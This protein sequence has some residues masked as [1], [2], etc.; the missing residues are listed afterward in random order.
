LINK[1]KQPTMTDQQEIINPNFSEVLVPEVSGKNMVQCN[2]SSNVYKFIKTGK[3]YMIELPDT[4]TILNVECTFA[5]IR[6]ADMRI[7]SVFVNG[8][9]DPDE[10]EY[11][12]SYQYDQFDSIH[13]TSFAY[14][15]KCIVYIS[16]DDLF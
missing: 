12:F 11:T 13:Y 14:R 1:N 3:R 15:E 6:A 16:M 8:K 4:N 9:K 2:K 5:A 10:E 7:K